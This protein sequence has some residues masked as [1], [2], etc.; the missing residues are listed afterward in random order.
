MSWTT[1]GS[2]ISWRS[3]GGRDAAHQCFFFVTNCDI[4]VTFEIRFGL[5]GCSRQH[6]HAGEWM[7]FFVKERARRYIRENNRNFK[8]RCVMPS[9]CMLTA[10]KMFS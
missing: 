8:F 2:E 4:N 5:H 6:Q 3:P 10:A 7:I 9:K 1:P